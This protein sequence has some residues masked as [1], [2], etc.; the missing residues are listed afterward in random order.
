MLNALKFDEMNHRFDQVSEAHAK[1]FKW[2]F[3]DEKN[4]K[5]FSTGFLFHVSA[6]LGAG[7]STLMKLIIN[8]PHVQDR[9]QQWA[10]KSCLPSPTICFLTHVKKSFDGMCRALLYGAIDGRPELTR[11]LFPSHWKA[12]WSA[13]WQASKELIIHHTE[14]REALKLLVDH[15]KANETFSFCFFIDGLDELEESTDFQH[16]HLAETLKEWSRHSSANI[17][18]CVS[19]REYSTFLHHFQQEQRIRLHDLTKRDME[20]YVKDVTRGV[21]NYG[22]PEINLDSIVKPLVDSIVDRAQGIFLWVKLVVNDL[23]N[24]MENGS[25]PED[26][27]LE[28]DKLPEG[29]NHLFHHFMTSIS[30]GASQKAYQTLDM[31]LRANEWWIMITLLIT[32][33]AWNFF[34]VREKAQPALSSES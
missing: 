13:P 23:C 2:I 22:T 21:R 28:V 9:L 27:H 4:E 6:K 30:H 19:S 10:G 14:V 7:K 29:I 25:R 20:K 31:I 32:L 15:S 26:L 1:T 16:R 17:K 24:Q 8:N 18:F 5:D 33:L 12:A 11:L 3:S 34:E